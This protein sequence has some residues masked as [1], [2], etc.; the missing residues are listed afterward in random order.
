MKFINCFVLIFNSC[1]ILC[2]FFLGP[3]SVW[4]SDAPIHIEA[5]RMSSTE[6][7]SSVVFTGNVDARQADVRIRSDEMTVYYTQS[8]QTKKAEKSAS[9]QVEKLVCTGNVEITRGEW[10][11]TAK[12]MT[13]LS[14]ERQVIL[15]D[16][17]KAWQNQNMVSGD[18]IIY[19]LDEGRS[20]VIGDTS[21]TTG[22]GKKPGE[23][24][25]SR[26][27]MTIRQK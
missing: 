14:R 2:L 5:N 8:E 13:Y 11:G 16:N 9:Q 6:R 7:T 17:A 23:K 25:P 12:K 3:I 20:E 18:K 27:N 15:T 4:A 22:K 21:A 24:K 26:V 1:L 19:Y 10:L